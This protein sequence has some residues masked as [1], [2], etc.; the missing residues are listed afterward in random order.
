MIITRDCIPPLRFML[1]RLIDNAPFLSSSVYLKS[2]SI[3]RYLLP[4]TLTPQIIM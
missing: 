2:F 3:K 4:L 1:I